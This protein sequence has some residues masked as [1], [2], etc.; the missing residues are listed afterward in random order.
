MTH[1]GYV[2]GYTYVPCPVPDYGHVL[3]EKQRLTDEAVRCYKT[4]DYN[5]AHIALD[6]MARLYFPT[7]EYYFDRIAHLLKSVASDAYHKGFCDGT[8]IR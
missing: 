4:R 6:E 3:K 8:E 1:G 7:N 5:G 2:P